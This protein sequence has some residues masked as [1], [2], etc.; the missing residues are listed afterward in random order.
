MNTDELR[1]LLKPR[2][3]KKIC[4]VCQLLE[5]VTDLEQRAIFDDALASSVPEADLRTAFIAQAGDAPGVGA[6]TKHRHGQCSGT[7]EH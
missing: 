2:L 3:N 4:S 6:I 5:R 1:A 7:R